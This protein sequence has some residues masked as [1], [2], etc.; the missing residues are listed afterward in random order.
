LSPCTWNFTITATAVSCE[1][2]GADNRLGCTGLN[3]A[4]ATNLTIE[5]LDGNENLV[6]SLTFNENIGVNNAAVTKSMQFISGGWNIAIMKST[7]SGNMP[8]RMD[9]EVRPGVI[10]TLNFSPN[11][12][13]I[14][15]GNGVITSYNFTTIPMYR[16]VQSCTFEP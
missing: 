4:E 8:I 13:T 7:F 15:N 11:T 5:F 2:A 16:G 9:V 12:T 3:G 10:K 14:T 6:S 1:G